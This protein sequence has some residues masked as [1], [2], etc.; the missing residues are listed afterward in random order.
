MM[1]SPLAICSGNLLPGKEEKRPHL[2]STHI[3]NQKHLMCRRAKPFLSALKKEERIEDG[4]HLPLHTVT[5]D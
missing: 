4:F 3:T 5:A 2:A 1:A